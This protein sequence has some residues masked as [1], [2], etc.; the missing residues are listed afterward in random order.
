M[1]TRGGPALALGAWQGV[2]NRAVPR[3]VSVGWEHPSLPQ[4]CPIDTDAQHVDGGRV[5][6]LQA[7]RA[8]DPH[9]F[10]P[11]RSRRW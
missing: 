4:F 5:K 9:W 8:A 10:Y 6:A 1:V 2:V 7:G 3:Q 11:S